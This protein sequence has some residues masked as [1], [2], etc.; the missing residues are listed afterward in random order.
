MFVASIVAVGESLTPVFI[1]NPRSQQITTI[2]TTD[3]NALLSQI[4]ASQP[5]PQPTV[6]PIAPVVTPQG[7]QQV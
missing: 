4:L 7:G 2:L 6:Q 3:V 1:H 5:T